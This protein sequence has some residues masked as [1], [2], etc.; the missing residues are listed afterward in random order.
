MRMVSQIDELLSAI[1]HLCVKSDSAEDTLSPATLHNIGKFADTLQKIHSFIEAQQNSSKFRRFFRQS[2]NTAQLEA[3]NVGLR[4]ALDVFGVR[5]SLVATTELADIREQAGRRHEDLVQLFTGK[6]EVMESDAVSEISKSL[7]SL[8]NSTTSI[9]L[10]PA[11]PKIFHGRNDE[12]KQLVHLLVQDPARAAVL[13]P[14]GIGKTSL[15]TAALHHPDI[16]A[17]YTNRYF[18]SC[19]S[20]A[21][22]DGLVSMIVSSVGLEPSRNASKHLLRHFSQSPAAIL[23][24]DN[25]ETCW[26]PL[27]SRNHVEEI[28][29]L[30]T[31]IPHLALLITMRGAERPSKVRWTRPFISPLEPLSNDAA[32]QTFADIA[33]YLDND[34]RTIREILRL[35]DNLPL[36]INLVANLAAFEGH[37]T[38]LLRWREEKTTLF[39]EGQDKRS[40]LDFSIQ[41]SLSSPR[42]VD[43]LGAHRLLSL[44]SLLPD[45]ILETELLQ[46]NLQIP[47]MGRS[48]TT[49]IRTSLAYIDHGKR[50]RVL[51]PIR[52]YIQKYSP[53]SPTLCRPLRRHFHDLILLW[54]DYQHLSS[55]GVAHR[56]AANVGNFLAV[57]AHGLN[58]D[59]PDLI[60]TLHSIIIF[61]SFFRISGRR[62]SGMLELVPPYLE[63]LDDH[64]LH[65]AY[66]TE[67]V[68]TWQY[69]PVPEPKTLEEDALSHF[70]A[71]GDIT[72]EARLFCAFGSYYRRHDNDIPK[73][74]KYWETAQDLAKQVNDPKIQCIALREAAEAIWQLGKYREAQAMA[75]DMRLLA[76]IHGLFVAEAQAIRIELLC[77]VSR[78]DLAPCLQLSAEARAI[79]AFC[80]LQGGPLEQALLASDADVHFQKT[81]YIEARTLYSQTVA[82]EAPLAQAYDRWSMA[83]IDIE[84]GVETNL[85]RQDLE[86]TKL[87]FESIM[88][89]PGITLCEVYLAYVDIREGLLV[90]AK[91]ALERAFS[92]TRGNDQEISILC[93]NKLGD[94]T[95]QLSDI[96]TTFGWTL[97]LLAFAQTGGNT[98]AIYHALSCLALIFLAQDDDGTALSLFQVA[99]DGFT[100]MDVHRSKGVCAVWMG[101]IF[102]QRGNEQKAIELWKIARPLFVRSSQFQD[103]ARIDER[104]QDHSSFTIDD[105]SGLSVMRK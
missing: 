37:E 45:G 43:S 61:D 47:D 69:H 46:C 105:K 58:W 31:D 85:I 26:E 36:A 28:L 62:S 13:G 6:F 96:Q 35:T 57:L 23:V 56:I 81:E 54:K 27:D 77:R 20:V 95:S 82:N 55:R 3:C 75:G 44:L 74:L 84:T 4:H 91:L 15:A 79:L 103:V 33:D 78:G 25:L 92:L 65:G 17:R 71:V 89:P 19:E 73:G 16:S 40:N 72:G 76:R 22:G 8:G 32:M 70:R 39:S 30:L 18:V 24:L 101:D 98:I 63:R 86:A 80:G 14:G 66:V 5:N 50:L 83:G 48:K 104:I 60:Q 87:I 64:H 10:L 53:P 93:L 29:S 90:K 88:N 94:P 21:N 49:L 41:L 67:F 11:S 102:H 34:K 42:M 12:L 51:V 7:F 38:V 9:L 2:E 1:I 99:F 97:V 68:S 59:E 100:A 52:E